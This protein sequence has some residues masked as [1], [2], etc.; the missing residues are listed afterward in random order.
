MADHDHRCVLR[1]LIIADV[2]QN[3]LASC[4]VKSRC[5]LIQNQNIRLHGNHARNSRAALLPAGKIKRRFFQLLLCNA[6]KASRA[7]HAIA[8]FILGESHILWAKGNISINCLFKQLIL[9]ILEYQSHLEADFTRKFCVFP[10]I[11]TV[12][13]NFPAS[14]LQKAVQMLNQCGFSGAGM[15]DQADKLAAICF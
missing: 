9:R 7:Q 14:W 8:D 4:R 10:D 12:K 15:T 3:A 5:W 11:L 2:L 1:T 6:D 13:Q